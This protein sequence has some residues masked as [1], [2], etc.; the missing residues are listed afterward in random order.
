MQMKYHS[1][2]GLYNTWCLVSQARKGQTGV[3]KADM[4]FNRDLR[5]WS[6]AMGHTPGVVPV[7]RLVRGGM[8]R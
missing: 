4:I 2:G 1:I 6:H 8:P 5:H 3:L 7:K